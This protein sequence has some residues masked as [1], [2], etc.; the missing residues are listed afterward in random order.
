MRPII[1]EACF[2]P[3]NSNYRPLSARWRQL[4]SL[5][6]FRNF[7]F[8]FRQSEFSSFG[9][10]DRCSS[11]FVIRIGKFPLLLLFA[12]LAA[13]NRFFFPVKDG[14]Q[15]EYGE[16][17]GSRK[18]RPRACSFMEIVAKPESGLAFH[19]SWKHCDRIGNVCKMR[20]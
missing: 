16:G 5:K 8:L 7:C 15:I 10:Y 11:R 1:S 4:H 9:I 18:R 2:P 6:N 13:I 3:K 20:R 14:P 17:A 19:F 12:R